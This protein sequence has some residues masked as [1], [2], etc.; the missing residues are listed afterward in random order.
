MEGD[1]PEDDDDDEEE[2]EEEAPS[3][4]FTPR[5]F[6]VRTMGALVA[7]FFLGVLGGIAE[8]V[9]LRN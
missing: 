2:E 1:L 8:G 3:S 4:T 9:D 5:F 7:A 6:W